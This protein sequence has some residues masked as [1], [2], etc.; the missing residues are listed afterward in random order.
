LSAA[1]SLSVV[2]L[3][4]MRQAFASEILTFSIVLILE[5]HRH[6]RISI[7]DSF[8]GEFLAFLLV[9][10]FVIRLSTIPHV[11]SSFT[12]FT[13]FRA[14]LSLPQSAILTTIA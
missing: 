14:Q 3:D 9:F 13:S 6:F 4:S 7:I 12:L 2:V 8:V 5:S 1:V 11:I 10:S